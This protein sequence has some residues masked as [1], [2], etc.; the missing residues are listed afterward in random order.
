MAL[1]RDLLTRGSRRRIAGI[2]ANIEAYRIKKLM[3]KR[4]EMNTPPPPKAA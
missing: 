1:L 4:K 2:K 3:T